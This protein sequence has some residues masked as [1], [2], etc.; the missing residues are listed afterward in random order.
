MT[1]MNLF[2][3][4]LAQPGASSVWILIAKATIILVAALGVTL[5]M[6][7][8]SAGARHLV[9]LVT[10]GS[11]LLVPVIA[12]WSPLRI[13]MLPAPTAQSSPSTVPPVILASKNRV[14]AAASSDAAIATASPSHQLQSVVPA[15][16]AR[17]VSAWTRADALSLV[18]LVWAVVALAIMASLAGATLSLRR[19][20]RSSE[21]VI[22]E[23][24]RAMLWEICDR[25]GLDEAPALLRSEQTQMP[26][27]CGVLHPTVVLPATCDNWTM[28]R[29]R[30]VLLHE[31]AHVTRHDLLGH[32]LGRLV[33]AVYWF[34]PLVWTAAKRLRSESERACDD[35][36][37]SCGTVASDYAEHLLDI[38]TSVR[39]ERTPAV[40]LAMARRK[41]FEGRMLAILDPDLVRAKPG[42]WKLVALIGSLGVLTILVGAVSPTARSAA[43]VTAQTVDE[44]TVAPT[45][46]SAS[47]A[48]VAQPPVAQ[49]SAAQ[50]SAEHSAVASFP[51][52]GAVAP[53]RGAQDAGAT[54]GLS[55]NRDVQGTV[56]VTAA[57]LIQQLRHLSPNVSDVKNAQGQPDDRP[58]ILAKVLR[59]DTSAAIRKV[60]AW[61]LASYSASPA[62]SPA[63]IAA[64][65]HDS[66]ADVREMAAWALARADETPAVNTSLTSAL[67]HDSDA[68]VRSTCAWALGT[69]GDKTALDALT[70]A[71]GNASPEVVAHSV[72]AIGRLQ[73]EHPPRG[74]TAKLSDRDPQVRT[75]TTWALFRIR[76][77]ATAPALEAALQTE[78]DKNVQIDEIH[79][80]AEIASANDSSLA[81][82][83]KFLDSPDA[84]V[85]AVA[86]KAIAGDGASGPWPWPWPQPRPFP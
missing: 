61:G 46:H 5:V 4:G 39:R 42:R 12:A 79:A 45:E 73:P 6:Q 58:E 32:T 43:V 55:L 84:R 68:K 23:S 63:L 17:T 15:T 27:A 2:E 41:E 65:E 78:Q 3:L 1:S 80:I 8:A 53:L 76:D 29:R 54:E 44:R 28:D 37:L 21:P 57:A 40:A 20:V 69:V 48:S 7:R 11:L 85:K 35:L 67:L 52:T 81:L 75:L 19:I 36:A 30:A 74:L 24:W 72:W 9:W 50:H 83:Q 22:D 49:S 26:F 70:G 64:L 14:S 33:S 47:S 60:A 31:I 56:A 16:P 13:A 59:T 10:L 38:V 66:N 25:F 62:V 51:N 77:A 71:L 86:V 18:L 34:H 82:L